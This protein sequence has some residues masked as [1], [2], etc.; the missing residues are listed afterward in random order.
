MEEQQYI[1][2]DPNEALRKFMDSQAD[3]RKLEELQKR[4]DKA[5][6]T[7]LAQAASPNPWSISIPEGFTIDPKLLEGGIT[8]LEFEAA[9]RNGFCTH[10]WINV[11]FAHIKMVCK[12]CDRPQW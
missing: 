1:K 5:N 6:E 4:L 12:H 10:E 7:A 9:P 2:L 3:R 11:S 8:K